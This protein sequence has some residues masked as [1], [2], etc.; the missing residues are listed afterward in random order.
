MRHS[1]YEGQS[2]IT[3]QEIAYLV[4]LEPTTG[5]LL[6]EISAILQHLKFAKNNEDFGR[7]FLNQKQ[8]N[9]GLLKGNHT[10]GL[11]D[12][13]LDHFHDKLNIASKTKAFE[14][15]NAPDQFT[16][17]AISSRN[18]LMEIAKSYF[19]MFREKLA[20]NNF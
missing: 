5:E 13:D 14:M 18:S 17:L 4:D 20:S 7:R 16:R 1:E 15:N 2:D 12:V 19:N 11:T 9:F 6:R 8:C 10:I 3:H